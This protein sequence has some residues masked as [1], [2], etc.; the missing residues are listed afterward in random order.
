M[1]QQG[2]K[3]RE[4][5]GTQGCADAEDGLPLGCLLVPALHPAP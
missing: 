2:H 5:N 4:G 1:D 3:P